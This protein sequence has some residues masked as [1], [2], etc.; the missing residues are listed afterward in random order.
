MGTMAMEK[1]AGRWTALPARLL[2]HIC[3]L[4]FLHWFYRFKI[5]KLPAMRF[6]FTLF[7]ITLCGTW[8]SAG[9][10]GLEDQ[11]RK[12]YSGT[13]QLLRHF[14]AE[15]KLKFDAQGNSLGKE[16]PAPWTVAAPIAITKVELK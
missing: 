7:A 3:S 8:A 2:Q 10:P 5:A 9:T 13:E 12:E 11:L 4:L 14:N 16:T 1:M 15:D 6:L